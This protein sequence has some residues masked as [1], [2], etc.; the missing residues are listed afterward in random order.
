MSKKVYD[1]F[2]AFQK[3]YQGWQKA[4]EVAYHN[5]FA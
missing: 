5:L 4:S 3:E 1:S 2:S